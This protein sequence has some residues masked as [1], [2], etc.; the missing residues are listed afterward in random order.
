MFFLTEEQV[1]SAK[2]V[3]TI[4]GF[5]VQIQFDRQ[6]SMLLEQYTGGNV[7]KHITLFAAFG[8]KANKPAP[9][10]R[11]LAAPLITR[12]ISDGLL[13]FTP[14]AT[15]EEAELLVA[16]LENM[17]KKYQDKEMQ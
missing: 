2:V 13:T 8:E 16:G 10:T 17:A 1:K 11:W 12:R 14:D 15:R 9:H 5:V 3:D 7:G 6:G 4:G